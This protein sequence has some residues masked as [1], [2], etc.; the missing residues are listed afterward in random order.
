MLGF[1]SP[2]GPDSAT[3]WEEK[4]IQESLLTTN[5]QVAKEAQ[6]VFS[7]FCISNP[8]I[9]REHSYDTYYH[10]L[11]RNDDDEMLNDMTGHQST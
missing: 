10:W 11:L 2:A 7:F 8:H 3:L 9:E 6:S 1:S 5:I 4:R